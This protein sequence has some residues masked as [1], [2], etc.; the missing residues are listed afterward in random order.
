MK[1]ILI[2]SCNNI[3]DNHCIGC[4]K[5]FKALSRREGEFARYKDE[6][7]EVVG[8]DYLWW[9]SRNGHSSGNSSS[10]N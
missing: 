5:C 6:E 7:V 8:L 3:R 1:K 9:L 2:V 4:L 10:K